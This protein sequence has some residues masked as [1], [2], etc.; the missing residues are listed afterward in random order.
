MYEKSSPFHISIIF[1]FPLR[2][3]GE[4][5]VFSFLLVKLK[6]I[7]TLEIYLLKVN[8]RNTGPC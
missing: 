5:T 7:Y 1:S 3:N 6:Q 2:I 8:D 4:L